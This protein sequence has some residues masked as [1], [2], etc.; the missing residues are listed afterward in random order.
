MSV[1][2]SVLD[3]TQIEKGSSSAVALANSVELAQ[4]AERLGYTRVWYA[5]HHS[6]IGLA[7]GSPE[8]MIAHIANH[9]E[10][11]RVGSGGVMLPNHAP[12]K[13]AEVFRLLEALHPGRIDLG[14]GRAPGTDTL[15]AYALRRSEE[16]LA[17][18]NY[19]QLL[20]E[21]L[22]YDQKAFPDDHPFRKIEVTPADVQLPPVWLLGSSGFS[23]QLAAE[24]GLGFSFAS[25]INRALAVDALRSYR[26]RFTPS[27]VWTAP[28]AMLAVG[29]V[30]GESQEHAEQLMK[31]LQIGFSDLVA[32]RPYQMP[33][34]E[35]AAVT[36]IEPFDLAR[37]QGF[38]GNWFVGTAESVAEEV[39]QLADASGADEVMITT[40]LPNQADRLLTVRG[41]AEAWRKVGAP[42]GTS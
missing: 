20:A 34:L 9:T 30:I 10:S 24:V 2:I 16:A 6:S 17:A 22:A 36:E 1:P 12:L 18:E 29:V 3:L 8:I 41:F 39:R 19:P 13:I 31:I 23:A 7:S 37:A 14:L 25:H 38:L 33:T 27:G 21:L 42:A 40:A 28:A 26:Q 32:G 15:T 11:I 35:E 5:E 4:E